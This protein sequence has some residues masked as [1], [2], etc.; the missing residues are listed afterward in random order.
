MIISSASA[1]SLNVLHE[2]A[3]NIALLWIGLLITLP[4]I[5]QAA[6]NK[7]VKHTARGI[8]GRQGGHGLIFLW[9]GGGASSKDD[10]TMVHVAV[11][12]TRLT[13]AADTQCLPWCT[14]PCRA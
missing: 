9:R 8:H 3:R 6:G 5:G 4:A 7:A 1:V 2:A 12:I 10:P 13:C 11:K 14:A